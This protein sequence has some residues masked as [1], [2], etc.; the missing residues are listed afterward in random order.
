MSGYIIFIH[1]IIVTAVNK[2]VFF[3]NIFII[4]SSYPDNSDNY[5]ALKRRKFGDLLVHITNDLFQITL[6]I[7]H[8]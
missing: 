3:T 4:M 2:R 1:Y 8:R 6:Y 7:P 5:S